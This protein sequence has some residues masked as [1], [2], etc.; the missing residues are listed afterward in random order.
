M[1]RKRKEET[2][3]LAAVASGS[4]NGHLNG[5]VRAPVKKHTPD[6]ETDENIFVFIPNIIGRLLLEPC[7]QQC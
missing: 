2:V 3:D 5:H 1:P 4:A 7:I 6:D